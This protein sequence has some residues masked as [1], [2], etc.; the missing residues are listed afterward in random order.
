MVAPFAAL[1]QRY[2]HETITQWSMNRPS[3]RIDKNADGLTKSLRSYTMSKRSAAI[4]LATAASIGIAAS[5]STD[6]SAK[7]TQIQRVQS[8]PKVMRQVNPNF[9]KPKYQINAGSLKTI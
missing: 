3:G 6:A 2:E 1:R 5:M 7:P 9:I 4:V 8:S